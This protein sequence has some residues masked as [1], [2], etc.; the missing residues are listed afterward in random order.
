[1]R[2]DLYSQSVFKIQL[3]TGNGSSTAQKLSYK[4]SAPGITII[5]PEEV[6]L[7][8]ARTESMQNKSVG[9]QN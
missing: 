5:S 4:V 3:Y 9:V 8:W 1:M 6:I 2:A 7:W